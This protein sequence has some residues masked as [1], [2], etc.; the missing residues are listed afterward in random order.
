MLLALNNNMKGFDLVLNTT[1]KHENK[2]DND[3]RTTEQV[4]MEESTKNT[5][6][7]ETSPPT[8]TT[9]EKTRHTEEITHPAHKTMRASPT[10]P[11]YNFTHTYTRQSTTTPKH[12]NSTQMAT[13]TSTFPTPLTNMQIEAKTGNIGVLNI[14]LIM[15]SIILAIFCI[16]LLSCIY[17]TNKRKLKRLL[18]ATNLRKMFLPSPSQTRH[19]QVGVLQPEGKANCLQTR[20]D[21]KKPENEE[22]NSIIEDTNK[23]LIKFLK[24]QMIIIS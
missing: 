22:S 23:E 18:L 24:S 12:L 3:K 11:P 16:L 7:D 14:I 13:L 5:E 20:K 6:R 1:K 9:Q 19:I 15:I 21:L 8:F 4:V 2:D 17:K 10:S